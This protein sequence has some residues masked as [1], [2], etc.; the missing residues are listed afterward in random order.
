[1]PFARSSISAFELANPFYIGA[2]ISF[3]TV[4]VNG[5]KTTTLANLFADTISTSQ[6]PNP[7][8]LDSTGKLS[9]PVYI[10]GPV[11]GTINGGINQS[12]AQDTGIIGVGGHFRGAYNAT[13]A[14]YYSDDLI[15]DAATGIIYSALTTYAPV[16]LTNDISLGKLVVFLTPADLMA[17][18]SAQ[19]FANQAAASATLAGVAQ[20]AASSSA[21]AGATSAI[22]AGNAATNAS[23]SALSAAAS[24]TAAA[25]AALG[26]FTT[27]DVKPT[28]KTVA[29]PGFIMMNDGTIGNAASLASNRA[30]ADT[31]PLYLLLYTIPDSYA[32]VTGGRGLSAI[33]DYNAGK[34]IQVLKALGRLLGI[35]GAGNGL[36][37]RALGQ[38]LG[39]E[40]HQLITSEI[41][42]HIH[43]VNDPAHQHDSG[44]HVG[45][46]AP[47]SALRR[48]SEPG[49][50]GSILT[51]FAATNITIGNTGGDGA[52]N[53]MPPT[54]FLNAMMKL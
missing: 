44:N 40:T 26:A 48:P 7:Q 23:N 31:Q 38:T 29:D 49:G 13:T 22:T 43:P 6:L 28:I 52:H 42:S 33:A 27:G 5:I 50:D 14:I 15:Q 17:T 20:T 46:P 53:N 35:A 37:A 21:S 54:L 8:Q 11:I 32:P 19:N 39:E 41:P 18:Q 4:D 12:E 25:L 16:S 51:G 47:G 24:A 1:M 45:S 10:D 36:T 30:N 3:Y 9:V 34:P 2:S